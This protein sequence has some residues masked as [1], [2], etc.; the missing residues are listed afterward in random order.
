[1][2]EEFYDEEP[3]NCCECCDEP[4][5]FTKIYIVS[6]AS[7]LN[8]F[9][10]DEE[11]TVLDEPNERW[12]VHVKKWNGNRKTTY[13]IR[14]DRLRPLFYENPIHQTT[15]D[16]IRNK[17]TFTD[18]TVE[19]AEEMYDSILSFVEDVMYFKTTLE[20]TAWN[21]RALA[22]DLLKAVE[23]K[24]SKSLLKLMENC[25]ETIKFLKD[26]PMMKDLKGTMKQFDTRELDEEDFNPIDLIG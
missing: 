4:T 6:D 7:W 13:T 14:F 19:K 16:E 10:K 8:K 2:T 1:M 17:K 20:N 18:A 22:W 9:V 23:T 11:V 26:D 3:C 5:P 24:N 12:E 25:K 21:L 15:F